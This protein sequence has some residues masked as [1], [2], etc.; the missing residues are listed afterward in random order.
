MGSLKFARVQ[1]I[2]NLGMLN[3]FH[4]TGIKK[5]PPVTIVKS[6][7]QKINFI[8]IQPKLRRFF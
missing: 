4:A 5:T 8:I 7:N 2:L 1:N 6:V 3:S